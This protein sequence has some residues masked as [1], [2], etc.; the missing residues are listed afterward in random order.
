[1][2]AR[3]NQKVKSLKKLM[4]KARKKRVSLLFSKKSAQSSK[5]QLLKPL[6]KKRHLNRPIV[7]SAQTLRSSVGVRPRK[8]RASK[9]KARS[10]LTTSLQLKD[11]KISCK[12]FN[13]LIWRRNQSSN[14]NQTSIRS[15]SSNLSKISRKKRLINRNYRSLSRNQPVSL[16]CLK[17]SRLNSTKNMS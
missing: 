13:S 12:S 7:L 6:K 3:A 1:M 11:L 17:V 10:I 2:R 4:I 9:V 8:K 5:K 16:T 15:R 14:L